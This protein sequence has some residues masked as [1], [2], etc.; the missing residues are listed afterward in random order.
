MI[1][2]NIYGHH[3]NISEGLTE[4]INYKAQL[5]NHHFEKLNIR[6]ILKK[7]GHKNVA[8]ANTSL[9][10]KSINISIRDSDMYLAISKL[11]KKLNRI[12]MKQKILKG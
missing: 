9:L 7:D 5:L 4:H 6:F 3:I 1:T 10:G 2:T 8:E 11:I 12:L